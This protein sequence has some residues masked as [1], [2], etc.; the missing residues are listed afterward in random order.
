MIFLIKYDRKKGAICGE[1]RSFPADRRAQAQR[2]RLDIELSFHQDRIPCEVVLIEAAD[3][4][5]LMRTHQ[6]YFK[7]P[8]ELVE[9]MT[10]A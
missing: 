5:A 2:E 6:R 3:E 7:N 1:I 4:D 8:R 9:S 10:Q